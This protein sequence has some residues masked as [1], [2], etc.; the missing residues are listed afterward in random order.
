MLRAILAWV[1]RRHAIRRRWREDARRLV[2]LLG[3]MA[4]YEAQRLA[5]RSRAIEDGQ[6][7][8]WAKVAAEVARVR[9]Q[10]F[11]DNRRRELTEALVHQV[12]HIRPLHLDEA[13]GA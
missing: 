11:W 8:H 7:L 6:F 10:G 9:R 1:E 3:P 4:Y 13:S 12:C 2:R 5:A